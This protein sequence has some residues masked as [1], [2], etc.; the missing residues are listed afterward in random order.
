VINLHEK[1]IEADSRISSFV[2]ETPADLSVHLSAVGNANVYL[3]AEHL[4][5]TGSFKLRGALNKMLSLSLAQLER[6][7]IAASNGNHGIAVAYAGKQIGVVPKIY[8][9]NGVSELKAGMIRSLGGEIVFFGDNPL[10][11]EVE[12]RRVAEETGQTF[13]SPYNDLDVIAGQGTIGVELI[14]QI[15]NLDAVFIAVGGGG[16]IS[17]IAG[18]LKAIRPG[19]QIVGCWP[20]NSAVLC[21]SIKAGRII[22][23]NEQPTLSDSTDGALE[24][25]SITLDFA[26]EFVDDFVLVTEEE[27]GDAMRII[28][29]HERWIVEGAAGVAVACYLQTRAEFEGKTIAIILC[30]RN[31]AYKKL[32]SI[33]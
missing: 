28:A 31:I 15:P 23:V 27:I 9:R 1:V 32:R 16:L 2:R 8:M 29:E 19:I 24:E 6:G 3:K 4:Q 11:A 12:A 17:G 5:H 14:R 18:Y 30:G 13:V 21:E 26:R 33:L 22:E 10:D 25:S 7:V 20:Q